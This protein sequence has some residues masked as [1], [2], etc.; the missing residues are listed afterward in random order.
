MSVSSQLPCESLAS[1]LYHIYHAAEIPHRKHIRFN[2][3]PR[4]FY[5][6]RSILCN[7][8]AEF[9]DCEFL[10]NVS[11]TDPYIT[12]SSFG[13]VHFNRCTFADVRYRKMS[14]GSSNQRWRS[15]EQR[16]WERISGRWRLTATSSRWTTP[17]RRSLPPLSAVQRQI[18]IR[19]AAVSI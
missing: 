13:E 9:S 15:S 17:S 19:F 11:R 2:K 10:C 14:I 4:R 6:G 3:R 7:G 12:V 8:K 18:S 1:E 16:I 5:S